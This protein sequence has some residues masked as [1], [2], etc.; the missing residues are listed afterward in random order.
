MSDA[1]TGPSAYGDAAEMSTK[2]RQRI[3]SS[4]VDTCAVQAGLGVGQK[5]LESRRPKAEQDWALKGL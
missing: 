3:T 5:G 4:I 2:F 1:S